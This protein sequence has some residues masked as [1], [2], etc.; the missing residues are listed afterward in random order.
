MSEHYLR[1]VL[2]QNGGLGAELSK[3]EHLYKREITALSASTYAVV[4]ALLAKLNNKMK[5]ELIFHA[6][7]HEI[8][9]N[10]DQTLTL[11]RTTIV[12]WEDASNSRDLGS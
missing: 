11:M 4:R 3:L 2:G 8:S 9:I 10:I 12:L 1:A 6:S 5:C 7:L